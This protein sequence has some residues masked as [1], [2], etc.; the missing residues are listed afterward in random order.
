MIVDL[1]KYNVFVGSDAHAYHKNLV[2]G[3]TSWRNENGEIPMDS[4]RDFKDEEIMTSTLIKNINNKVGKNDLF[5][6]YGD[7]S[8]GGIDNIVR[9]RKQINCQNIININ[10][11]HD[12]HIGL[13]KIASYEGKQYEIDK[14]FQE[15]HYLGFYFKYEKHKFI[16]CHFPFQSHDAK[17]FINLHGHIHS[18][19]DGRFLNKNQF[20]VGFCGNPN[21]E[22]YHISEVLNLLE[23]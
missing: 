22:P 13:K 10:G 2:A 16:N 1:S 4:V 15:I 19:G 12:Q 11:N 6:H 7:F 3:V 5:I 17:E 9:F 18:K 8:F 14:L 21:F 20:D 23:K